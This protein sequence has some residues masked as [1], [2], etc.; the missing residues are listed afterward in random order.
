M[1]QKWLDAREGS[2]QQPSESG[3]RLKDE[4]VA[5]VTERITGEL[6][7]KFEEKLTAQRKEF[8]EEMKRLLEAR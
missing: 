2:R 6:T 7:E 4:I 5:E 3:T 8:V 1:L